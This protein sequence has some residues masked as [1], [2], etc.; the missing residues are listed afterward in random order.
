MPRCAELWRCVVFFSGWYL[1][2]CIVVGSGGNLFV[3]WL[4][5]SRAVGFFCSTF[6]SIAS[7]SFRIGRYI[8][9]SDVYISPNGLRMALQVPPR[10]LLTVD[11]DSASDLI[12]VLTTRM[13]DL[14]LP[15]ALGDAYALASSTAFSLTATSGKQKQVRI[16]C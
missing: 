8:S 11:A 10:R 9:E 15:P 7:I 5:A 3:L 16:I 13:L 1:G 2:V 4:L 6:R 12:D 14:C